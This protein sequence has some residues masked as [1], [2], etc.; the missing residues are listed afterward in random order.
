MTKT[1]LPKQDLNND[2]TSRHGDDS[3]DGE[4]HRVPSLG[5]LTVTIERWR[6]SLS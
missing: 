3:V 2:N 4:S 1:W 6:I 5:V